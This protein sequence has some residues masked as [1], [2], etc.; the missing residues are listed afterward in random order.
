M[1]TVDHV[2]D[3]NNEGDFEVLAYARQA[4]DT[5]QQLYDALMESL[6]CIVCHNLILGGGKNGRS[7]I[8]QCDAGHLICGYCLQQMTDI[9]QRSGAYTVKCPTCRE[10][11]Q[12]YGKEVQNR[13][14]QKLRAHIQIKCK[15]CKKITPASEAFLHQEYTCTHRLVKE[16]PI[17]FRCGFEG[18]PEKVLPHVLMKH[19]EV[20]IRVKNTDSDFMINTIAAKMFEEL[21][22]LHPCTV[23]RKFTETHMRILFDRLQEAYDNLMRSELV[24]RLEVKLD[25]PDIKETEDNTFS[26]VLMEKDVLESKSR[27]ES[28]KTSNKSKKQPE[29][30]CHI[31]PRDGELTT[32]T[33]VTSEGTLV[34]FTLDLR[35]S[36]YPRVGYN[37]QLLYTHGEDPS[38]IMCNFAA[39]MFVN[40]KL[41]SEEKITPRIQDVHD[42]R[43]VIQPTDHTDVGHRFGAGLSAAFSDGIMGDQFTT[44]NVKFR[45]VYSPPVIILGGPSRPQ[46][47]R[48]IGCEGDDD[49]EKTVECDNNKDEGQSSV[50]KKRKKG[51]LSNWRKFVLKDRFPGYHSFDQE[52]KEEVKRQLSQE[53]KNMSKSEKDTYFY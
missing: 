49:E 18:P 19:P 41:H 34:T 37:A 33:F 38:T 28:R 31:W 22:A 29:Y 25:F 39:T 47:H 32:T 8:A 17:C 40:G 27:N 23:Q 45:I 44:E 46:L 21:N 53:W 5:G 9:A 7:T 26:V 11:M 2:D 36:A 51:A 43:F 42:G 14:L 20:P 1:A 4:G 52:K 24:T 15:R 12:P 13:A 48:S 30:I 35:S 50:K 16:C 10:I 6:T 3:D